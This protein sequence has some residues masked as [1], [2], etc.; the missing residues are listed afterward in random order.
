MSSAAR[1]GTPW[2]VWCAVAATTSSMIGIQWDISWHRTIGRDAFL[3]PAHMAIY[4]CG[5]LAGISCGYLILATTF[6]PAADALR[7][8]SVRIWGFR[9]P[10]GA[11]VA[12]WG[13]IAMLTSAPFDDWWHNAYGLDVKIISPPHMVL[14]VG[15]F[16]VQLGAL[17]LVLS[18]KNNAPDDRRR[19]LDWL[20]VFTGGLVIANVMTLIMEYTFRVAIHSGVYYRS[21][22]IAV[23]LFLV[24]I[25]QSARVPWAAT[26]IALVYFFFCNGMNWILQLFPGEPKLGPVTNPVTHFVPGHFPVLMFVPAMALDYALSRT[27]PWAR[28]KRAA[29]GAVSFMGVLVATQ[30]LFGYFLLSPWS[31]NPVF[32]THLWDYRMTPRSYT[33]RNLFYP[34]DGSTASFAINMT[35]AFAICFLLAWRGLAWANWMQKVRR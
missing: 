35:L 23:P 14:A 20:F 1:N 3:T 25:S 21:I 28:W 7:N 27:E 19:A 10:L 30:W 6:S 26:R 33:A 29:A 24:A 5:V 12:A 32:Y 9:G 15:M 4:L 11:F 31:R 17:L 8:A 22:A 13:G 18:Y 2:Y 34:M 16:A